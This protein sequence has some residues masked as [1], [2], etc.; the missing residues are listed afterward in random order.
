MR[1]S[2]F[3]VLLIL[4]VACGCDDGGDGD[5]GTD[6]DAG[7]RDAGGAT[8]DAGGGSDGGGASDGGSDAGVDAGPSGPNVDVSDPQLYT[9]DFSP[10]DA[11]AMSADGDQ[12]QIGH[13]DTRVTPRGLLVV[14][15]H[16]AN[17]PATCGSRAHSQVIASFGYHVINPCYDSD[18]GIGN[19]TDR[20]GDCR[21]EAF[22]GVDHHPFLDTAPADS[23]ERRIAR[24]LAYLDAQ[25]PEGDWSYFLADADTPAWDR[26]IIS[27]ISHGASTAALIGKVRDVARVVSLS[28]PNDNGQSWITM[29]GI[30]PIDRYWSFT[31]TTDGQHPAILGSQMDLGMVGDPT[32][33]DGAS[34]PYGGSHRLHSS[35]ATTDG[36]TSTQA[37]GASPRTGG[38]Y[39]FLPVWQTMY[40][41]D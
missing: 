34:P 29:T 26:I 35:A 16:G 24:G 11:D 6:R 1:R 17:R 2:A 5:A 40:G 37:G 39:D 25:N 33:V 13:L 31:H 41:A 23:L 30:T 8:G 22:E 38:E 20:V 4:G 19:C 27:G 21:L 3:G 9:I 7:R 10:T 36:H 12:T 32:D 18:Y 15:L 28:G 14:Y